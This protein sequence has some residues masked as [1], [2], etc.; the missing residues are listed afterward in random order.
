MITGFLTVEKIM[1]ITQIQFRDVEEVLRWSIVDDCCPL[2]TL[3]G[4]LI[5]FAVKLNSLGCFAEL[6]TVK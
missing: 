2:S 3:F 5:T 1:F 6:G 4:L